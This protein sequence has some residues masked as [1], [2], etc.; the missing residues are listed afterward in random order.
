MRKQSSGDSSGRRSKNA[1]P[2]AAALHSGTFW[3]H[4][5]IGISTAAA[6][7]DAFA[8]NSPPPPLSRMSSLDRQM[9]ES[10]TSSTASHNGLTGTSIIST[11]SGTSTGTGT[12]T[13]TG[14]REEVAD[15]ASAADS[16]NTLY[17]G[18]W[19]T[20]L[21]ASK[22]G[23]TNTSTTAASSAAST[24][25]L[26]SAI[27]LIESHGGPHTP[28]L[29]PTLGPNLGSNLGTNVSP[30]RGNSSSSK[31]RQLTVET[32]GTRR[33]LGR[34]ISDTGFEF[35]TDEEHAAWRELKNLISSM[36]FDLG[37]RWVQDDSP[38]LKR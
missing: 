32:A 2:T 38:A 31:P 28:T 37:S 26:L 35:G 18:T 10:Q 34:Q 9:L 3:R 25:P 14:T 20:H 22:T 4:D 1:S 29:G 21:S 5:H 16:S 23:N 11:G 30:T 8:A 33:P 17:S 6:A 27:S 12:G 7:A 24:P 36:I 19:G 15:D 13:G